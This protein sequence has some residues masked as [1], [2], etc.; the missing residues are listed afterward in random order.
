MFNLLNQVNKQYG[1]MKSLDKAMLSITI[2]V[3]TAFLTFFIL[4]ISGRFGLL[5]IKSSSLYKSIPPGSLFVFAASGI[6]DIQTGEIIA[7][8]EDRFSNSLI[9]HRVIGKLFQNDELF[10]KTK[11]D[12]NHRVNSGL[13]GKDELVGR[14]VCIIPHAGR[15]FAFTRTPVGMLL[16]NLMLLAF[17]LFIVVDKV[18]SAERRSYTI[19]NGILVNPNISLDKEKM[20]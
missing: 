17:I 19:E 5:I 14:K 3:I 7:F 8:R 18:K 1:E 2:V 13:I 10:I 6:E 20:A 12:G 11:G 15:V 9:T 16:V 4:T